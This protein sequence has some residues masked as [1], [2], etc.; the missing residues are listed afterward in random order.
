MFL[1]L[2]DV[3]GVEDTTY[4][5]SSIE[6]VKMMLIYASTTSDALGALG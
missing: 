3:R 5:V 4:M 1:D 2:K 6:M